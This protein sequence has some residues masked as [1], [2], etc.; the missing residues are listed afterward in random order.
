MLAFWRAEDTRVAKIDQRVQIAVGG[1]PDA[2]AA[3]AVA[4]ARAAHRNEF[5]AAKR[6]D[7]VAAIAGEYLDACFVKEF[8]RG[9]VSGLAKGVGERVGETKPLKCESPIAG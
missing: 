1:R 6:R 8:H 5:F 9:S 4:T 3:P 7:A 2:A